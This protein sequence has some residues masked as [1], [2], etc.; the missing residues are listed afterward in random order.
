VRQGQAVAKSKKSRRRKLLSWLAVDVAVAAVVI[1]LLLYKP[2]RY[3]PVLPAVAANDPNGR[4]VHPYLSRDLGSTF[5]NN[6]QKQ[7]PFE[8]V[9]VDQS[10]NEAIA[11]KTW[12]SERVS[13][14]GPQ[15]LFTPGQVLLMG[16]ADL[17]GA[18]FVVTVELNPRIDEQGR[19]ALALESFKVGAMNVTPL[20]KM[21]GRKMYQEQL[22]TGSVDLDNLGTKIVASL[23]NEESFD[24]VVE[25]DDKRVR[26][27]GF[28]IAQGQLTTRFDPVK[29]AR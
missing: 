12:Q 15:I 22:D 25:V 28:D 14:S 9:V 23:L 8:I 21:M 5:Y 18:K 20:A 4:A 26:L 6:V 11:D 13:L 16:T 19:L 7:Q 24:P 10:L 27:T 29:P 1:A 17:E 3:N 2:S